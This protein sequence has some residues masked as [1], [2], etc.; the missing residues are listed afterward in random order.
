MNKTRARLDGTP[1]QTTHIMA[2]DCGA[3]PGQTCTCELP[4]IVCIPDSAITYRLVGGRLRRVCEV[5]A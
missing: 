3:L 1:L 5:P 2:C 4:P